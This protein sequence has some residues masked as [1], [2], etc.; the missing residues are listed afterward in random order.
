MQAPYIG[1][2]TGPEDRG[3][4]ASAAEQAAAAAATAVAGVGRDPGA[5]FRLKNSKKLGCWTR[6]GFASFHTSIV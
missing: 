2:E 1:R 3:A 4:S 6:T 5:Q